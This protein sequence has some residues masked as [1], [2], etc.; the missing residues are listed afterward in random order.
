M[1]ADR[2]FIANNIIQSVQ[3]F[4]Q[5]IQELDADEFERSVHGKWSAGQDLA[6]LIKTLKI[7]GLAFILPKFLLKFLFGKAN[8]PSRSPEELYEKYKG[9]LAQ[10]GKAPAAF[11]PKKVRYAQAD[12]LLQQHEYY[13]NQ[14]IKR[15]NKISEEDLDTYLLPHPLIGKI[16][17]REM[18]CFVFVHTNHHYRNLKQ[19]LG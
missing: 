3:T 2:P 17:M 15:L 12:G 11:I 14:L 8:R 9:S 5:L 16:T 1:I 19:K 6:H 10:G 13:G 7:I 4:N 18:L